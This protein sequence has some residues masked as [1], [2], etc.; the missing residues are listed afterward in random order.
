MPKPLTPL[1]FPWPLLTLIAATAGPVAALGAPV[2]STGGMVVTAQHH[3]SDV[4]AA[5]L[6]RGGNAID[7]AVAVGYAL[8]VVDPCCGNI[9]GGGFM[10]IHTVK[11]VNTFIDFR[12]RAP[13]AATADMY[14]DAD[15]EPDTK[16]SVDGYLSVGT[17]GSVAGL[18][19]ARRHYGTLPR[20]TLLAPAIRLARDGFVL[21]PQDVELLGQ[22][23]AQFRA[24]PAAARMFLNAGK[25]YDVGERFVQSDLARTLG[26]ISSG[27]EAAFYRGPIAREIVAASK[28][29][30]GL[31]TLADFVDY[32]VEE[33][34]P[35][36]CDYRGYTVLLPPPPSSGGVT[37][38]EMF[39]ILSGFDRAQLKPGTASADHL[40]T[41]AARR[42]YFDR[43]KSLGDPDFVPDPTARLLAPA[44]LATLRST[45]S[46]DR[47]TPSA[48]L[49]SIGAPPE[50]RQT[51]HYSVVDRWGNAVSVTYTI[52]DG[53][54]AKVVAGR[55]GVLLNDEMDDFTSKPGSPNEYGLV[56][57]KAN[58]IAPGKRPLSSMSPA[59]VLDHGR[60]RWVLGAPGGARI[61][62]TVAQVL[63]N[64]I[65]GG[66]TPE[67]AVDAPRWHHQWLPDVVNL[68]PGALSED[69]RAKL[70]AMGHKVEPMDDWKSENAVELIAVSPRSAG[71]LVMEGVNDRRASS[72]SAKGPERSIR[73]SD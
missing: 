6:R 44:Y 71:G 58:A 13:L 36:A 14:L 65:D 48:S 59:I 23:T 39:G 46:L 20:P 21:E 68:E 40:L 47:A 30:G 51:T 35:V 66:M 49:G 4:G 54:G 26:L 3:A 28:A 2:R 56:Q 11:G 7:A 73:R 69:Q 67:A 61:I 37:I 55:T 45:I 15:G 25:P 64:M 19:Y 52:N 50:N 57:G 70:T 31:L 38:C 18:E 10:M 62:T 16:K 33:R 32:K 1:R 60:V 42:A 24:D 34:A 5:V 8:A 29:H 53:F 9:G 41:E 63:S 72:G 12:E 17:P 22:H 27:G 43:N